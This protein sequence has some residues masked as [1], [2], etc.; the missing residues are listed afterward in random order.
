MQECEMFDTT[1]QV[2]KVKTYGVDVAIDLPGRSHRQFGYI[3]LREGIE[4]QPGQMITVRVRWFG[5]G[6]F[7]ADFL[8]ATAIKKDTAEELQKPE[9]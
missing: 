1:A 4:L 9:F 3:P 8:S 6:Q 7:T 2:R 5:S